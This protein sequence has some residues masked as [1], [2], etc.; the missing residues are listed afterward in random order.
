LTDQIKNRVVGTLVLFTLAIIFLPD[1]FDGKKNQLKEDFAV[2]PAKPTLGQPVIIA[3]DVILD[4]ESR[5]TDVARQVLSD[6]DTHALAGEEPDVVVTSAVP[7]KNGAT[8]A[9]KPS[10]KPFMRSGWVIQMGIFQQAERV[11]PYLDKLR[12]KGFTAF[13]VPLRP[14]AGEATTVYVGPS[15]DKAALVKLQPKL[16]SVFNES[17]Y[18]KKF[19]PLTKQ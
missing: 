11:Q 2:I 8:P 9:K 1:I 10:V 4:Q 12:A 17:G 16:K 13:S 14:R 5:A 15:L 19:S 18:I 7:T 6:D 3:Q